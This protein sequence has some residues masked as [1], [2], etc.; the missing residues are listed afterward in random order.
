MTRPHKPIYTLSALVGMVTAPTAGDAFSGGIFALWVLGGQALLPY[1]FY[2][3]L[4]ATKPFISKALVLIASA[5][6]E[7]VI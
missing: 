2:T 7:S 4:N 5:C 3:A 6:S 1:V